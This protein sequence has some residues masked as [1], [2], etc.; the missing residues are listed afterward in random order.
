[1]V[2]GKRKGT[3]A[4]ENCLVLNGRF[5][6]GQRIGG[7]SFGEIFLGYD[8]QTGDTVAVKVERAKTNHPQ[9]L[10]ESRYYSC[11]SQGHAAAYMPIIYGFSAEGDYNVMVMELMGHSL[12][13]LHGQCGNRF[14]LKTTLMLADQMLKL[15]ELVHCCSIL[16]RDIKPDNF[17]MGLG[18]KTHHV[19]IIDFGLA[20]KYRDPR[21][22]VHIPYKEGKSLTGTARYCSVNTHLGIEQSRRDD[23]EGIA[24][25]LIYFFKGALPWQGLKAANKDQKY[26][27]IAQVK[28]CTPI[29]TL[30]S[31]IP[32]EFASFVNYARALRFEDRPDYG[33]LRAMFRRVFEREGYQE[34]YV[35]DWTVRAMQETIATRQ[36]KRGDHKHSKK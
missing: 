25:L 2:G 14:S 1:M 23:L 33:Y 29:E 20:K 8:I 5:R 19:H 3:N 13:D 24:Y 30:C 18:K 7:G 32:V 11:I 10:A 12:E 36:R 21:T 16:H 22:H 6:V 4:L 27:L 17:I 28:M 35:Y 31:G 34:D 9:L 15:I 26:G